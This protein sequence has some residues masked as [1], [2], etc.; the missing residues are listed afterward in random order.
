MPACSP[1][2]VRKAIFGEIGFYVLPKIGPVLHARL[3]RVFLCQRNSAQVYGER[4]FQKS[5]F[6]V[7]YVSSLLLT[8]ERDSTRI[9][10]VTSA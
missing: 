6:S 5:S 1:V 4:S 9:F 3:G 7:L 8:L 2:T 10:R